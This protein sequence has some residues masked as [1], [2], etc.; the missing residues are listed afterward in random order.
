MEKMSWPWI[1]GFFEGEGH[2]YW[3]EGK[4]GTKQGLHGRVIIGQK[5]KRPLQAIYNFLIQ[6]G[7]YN[8]ILYL[9]PAPKENNFR[10]SS[11]IWVLSLTTRDDVI[12]FYTEISPYLFEKQEKAEYVLERLVKARDE[13]DQILREAIRMKEDGKFWS[14]ISRELGVGRTSILNYA[15]SAGIDVQHKYHEIGMDFRSDRVRRGLCEVCGFERGDN[16]T[17]RKCRKCADAYNSYIF[18]RRNRNN[19]HA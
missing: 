7:F 12:H 19:G 6:Q 11:A 10:K 9:R 18:Q 13:R 15:K 2:V 3:Q 8:P 17:K 16:G 4:K 5:D 1:S 14:D